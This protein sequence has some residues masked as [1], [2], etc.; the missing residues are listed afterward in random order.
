MRRA[1]SVFP[2]VAGASDSIGTKLLI[3]TQDSD[4]AL[5][6][7]P[8]NHLFPPFQLRESKIPIMGGFRQ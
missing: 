3:L 4:K 7:L 1:A 5:E 6:R 8:A 2:P